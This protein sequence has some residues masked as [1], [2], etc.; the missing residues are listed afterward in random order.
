MNIYRLLS[1]LICFVL[2]LTPTRAQQPLKNNTTDKYYQ[3]ALE[4]FQNKQYAAAE[5]LFDNYLTH[6]EVNKPSTLTIDAEYYSAICDLY[7]SLIHI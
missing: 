1:V 3:N 4:L 7:L 2:A 5:Q 6:V